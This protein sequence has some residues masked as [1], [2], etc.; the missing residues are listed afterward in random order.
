MPLTRIVA[1]VLGCV[2]TGYPIG[3]AQQN[4]PF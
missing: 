3:Q 4:R 1:I 2:L